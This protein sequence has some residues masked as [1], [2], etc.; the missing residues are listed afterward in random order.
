MSIRDFL[1]KSL[2]RKRHLGWVFSYL[3]IFTAVSAVI[4]WYENI[5]NRVLWALIL[6]VWNSFLIYV[7]TWT[8]QSN[9]GQLPSKFYYKSGRREFRKVMLIVIGVIM[10]G[11]A[12]SAISKISN[13]ASIWIG[14]KQA[15][16]VDVGA[17]FTIVLGGASLFGLFLTFQL[18]GKEKREING[19]AD[20]IKR[21]SVLIEDQ[22]N[23]NQKTRFMA[24]TPATG[25]LV[26]NDDTWR[27]F[28]DLLKSN[29]TYVELTCLNESTM[30]DWFKNY[31]PLN[32]LSKG[33]MEK[34]VDY[35]LA[36]VNNI[37]NA[38]NDQHKRDLK[39]FPKPL[40][41]E[42]NDLPHA[43]YLAT[44]DRAIVVTPFFLPSH[45]KNPFQNTNFAQVDMIGFETS[46][47]RIV[48]AVNREIDLRRK[49]IERNGQSQIE[50]RNDEETKTEKDG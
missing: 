45:V 19:F 8:A 6:L 40:R 9:Y 39:R 33:E 34:R 18:V 16:T 35:G 32:E 47:V 10:I 1:D 24:L 42:W 4:P 28:A 15:L 22:N 26:L 13:S 23:A 29:S 11:L 3:V 20:F 37:F 31:I 30:E 46:D 43:Y 44:K 14:F 49:S 12:L 25:C 21:A 7:I 5:V 2:L 17:P 41:G 36:E 50:P 38:L 48:E 27:G